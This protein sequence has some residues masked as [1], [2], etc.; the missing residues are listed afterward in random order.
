MNEGQTTPLPDRDTMLREGMKFYRVETTLYDG[1][2]RIEEI[3][4]IPHHPHTITM[5]GD[6]PEDEVTLG[7]SERTATARVTDLVTGRVYDD[8][9]IGTI[10]VERMEEALNKGFASTD[11][12]HIYT[13]RNVAVEDYNECIDL[14]IKRLEGKKLSA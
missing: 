14:E 11:F 3:A 1:R 7:V 2:T 9:F 5:G 8:T 13:D 10:E 4:I 6:G 12:G